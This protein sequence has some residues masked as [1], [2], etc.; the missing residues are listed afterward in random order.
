MINSNNYTPDNIT[1]RI[2]GQKQNTKSYTIRVIDVRLWLKNLRLQLIKQQ[3]IVNNTNNT[4]LDMLEFDVG[5]CVC[6]CVCVC[7]YKIC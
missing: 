6:V 2:I 3:L 5:V 7:I 4:E 1:N